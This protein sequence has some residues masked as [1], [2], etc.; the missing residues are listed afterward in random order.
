MDCRQ[1][2]ARVQ[3]TNQPLIDSRIR[4]TDD[5][6]DEFETKRLVLLRDGFDV[7]DVE[8]VSTGARNDAAMDDNGIEIIA[9]S[10]SSCWESS[11]AIRIIDCRW[12]KRVDDVVVV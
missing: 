9:E 6:G 5:D 4:G 11:S 3:R 7:D 1:L 2:S 10:A 8:R 12:T